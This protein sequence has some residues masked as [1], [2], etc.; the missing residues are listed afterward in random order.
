MSVPALGSST[1]FDEYYQLPQRFKVLIKSRDFSTTLHSFNGFKDPSENDI[2]IT[3]IDIR[4]GMQQ[5][6]SF[7]ISINDPDLKLNRDNVDKGCLVIVQA[8]K[9]ED[10]LRNLI[11]GIVY[12]FD[13]ERNYT[14]VNWTI[15][16][17]G[18]SAILNHTFVNFVKAA[19]SETLKNGETVFKKDPNFEA[20]KLFKQLFESTL[21]VPL[22]RKTVQSRGQFTL[23]GISDQITA[24]IPAIKYPLVSAAS[25]ANA[26][27]DMVGAA[28]TID[29]YNKV[30]FFYPNARS[31]GIIIRDHV[32]FNDNGDYTAYPVAY[33]IRFSSSIDPSNGF[34]NV[35][36]GTSNLVSIYSGEAGATNFADLFNQ[37]LSQMLIPGAAQL[38]DLTF[39]LSKVGAGTD[40]PDPSTKKLYGFV[41]EDKPT[42]DGLVHRPG[43]EMVA[44]F[45]IALADIQDT[46]SPIS[47]IN[48]K[49]LPGV[50][51]EIDKEH[52][53]VL[54]EI[55]NSHENTVR[56]FHDNDIDTPTD[57]NINK[58]RW[59]GFRPLP[60][61][62]EEKEPG[63]TGGRS[64]GDVFLRR[65]WFTS[66]HGPVFS[67]A[68]LSSSKILVQARNPASISR[69]TPSFPVEARVDAPWIDYAEVMSQYLNTLVHETGKAPVSFD[70]IVTT[71]PNV[72]Y[73][74]G[75]DVQ[76]VDA[77]LGFP[78]Q[79][80]FLCQVI[81][82]HYWADAETYG[83]GNLVCEV[84][85]KGFESPL[86]RFS[87]LDDPFLTD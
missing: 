29:E 80:N 87:D 4:R 18:S 49:M 68:F 78:E 81:E 45:E 25:V 76:F 41:Q 65:P 86:D 55:G 32:N 63:A 52:W 35:L 46:P 33:P 42:V 20:Y 10:D 50:R 23:E 67:H 82:D 40:A 1:V 27:A 14:D 69:W 39:V 22:S 15:S 8:G 58:I 6:G 7:S 31:S 38:R 37:D 57:F 70:T 19:P 66:S 26:L 54:Q 53:I 85:L 34:A 30:Q 62:P 12:N 21:I 43:G 84:S 83:F 71:I 36:F 75:K 73:T 61:D 28:W 24:N 48:L 72:L 47:K 51:M 3:N 5:S 60:D 56:W 2:A 77:A 16:G 79:R 59:S 17:H 11:W 64:D 44:T 13:G 9:T 74:P